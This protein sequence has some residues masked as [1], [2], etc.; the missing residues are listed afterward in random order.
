MLGTAQVVQRYNDAQ[1]RHA[2]DGACIAA[3]QVGA[4]LAYQ[5]TGVFLASRCAALLLG[6]ILIIAWLNLR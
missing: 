2:N 3:M 4:A 6:S 1:R 5:Q